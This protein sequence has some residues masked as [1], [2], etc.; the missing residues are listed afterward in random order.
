M[1]NKIG[2][3]TYFFVNG[4]QYRLKGECEIMFQTYTRESLVGEDGVHGYVE[5]P[6][7]PS[8]KMSFTM[9]PEIDLDALISAEDLTLTIQLN[10][11]SVWTMGGAFVSG[12][13]THTT[14][15]NELSVTFEGTTCERT[16]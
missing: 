7:A 8:M 3:I 2:G 10:D 11:R 13:V 5:T 1:A 16:R 6:R 4:V 9:T 12:E 15:E 14:K